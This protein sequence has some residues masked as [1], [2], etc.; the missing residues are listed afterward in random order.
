MTA[1]TIG[2]PRIG[3]AITHKLLAA[4]MG[5]V[6]GDKEEAR[7]LAG[8]IFLLALLHPRQPGP[9]RVAHGSSEGFQY[10]QKMRLIQSPDRENY[11]EEW[12]ARGKQGRDVT[13][14]IPR[15]TA[16]VVVPRDGAC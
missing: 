3:I 1:N 14:T 2:I 16:V 6:H 8:A 15:A 13:K 11:G 4:Y 7:A 12:I 5:H 9:E 10:S